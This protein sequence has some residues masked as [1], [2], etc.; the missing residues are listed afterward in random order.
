MRSRIFGP[1]LSFNRTCIAAIRLTLFD[2]YQFTFYYLAQALPDV[3][4]MFQVVVESHFDFF[5]FL[6]EPRA[7][8][9]QLG[10]AVLQ[11]L[12]GEHH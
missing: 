11:P 9:S 7:A 2:N 6:P 12:E 1:T 5:S 8:S 4:G 3:M 10:R